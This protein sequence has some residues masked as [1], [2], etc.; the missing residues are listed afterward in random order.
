ML[1][2]IGKALKIGEDHLAPSRAVLHDYGNVSSSSTW[3]TLSYIETS[4]GVA[5]GDKVL[6]VRR[7]RG[8]YYDSQDSG[9]LL[10]QQ[11]YFD[12]ARCHLE[13]VFLL[14]VVRL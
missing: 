13:T 7:R 1:D 8:I 11:S 5:E 14:F 12:E 4:Q 3:Y 2:G 10:I 6:Q 9:L